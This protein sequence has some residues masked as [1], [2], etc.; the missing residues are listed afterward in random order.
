MTRII[1]SSGVCLLI[2]KEITS[3]KNHQ[4]LWKRCCFVKHFWIVIASS[5]NMIFWSELESPVNIARLKCWSLSH[6]V[7]LGSTPS[8]RRWLPCCCGLITCTVSS[9]MIRKLKHSISVRMAYTVRRREQE[10]NNERPHGVVSGRS[11]SILASRQFY[12]DVGPTQ[13]NKP[14]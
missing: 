14:D 10:M 7:A 13:K 5:K 9:V 2:L 11:V 8:R 12:K 4:R 3:A 1:D 6:L